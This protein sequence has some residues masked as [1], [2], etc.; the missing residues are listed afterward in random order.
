MGTML[1]SFDDNAKMKTKIK[2]IGVGGAGCNAVERMKSEKLTGVELIAMNT[3]AQQ[4]ADVSVDFLTIGPKIAKGQGAGSNP[5]VGEKA[6]LESK[7][8]ISN[9]IKGADMVYISAGMGGGTGSGA[10]PV[11]AEMARDL[12]ALTVAVVTK[13][14]KFEGP[15]R[16]RQAKEGLQKLKKC[17][18]TLIVINNQKIVD[19][20]KGITVPQAFESVDEV[21]YKSVKGITDLITK[22]GHVNLDF[23][24]VKTIMKRKEN[25]N[26]AS[27]MMG[28]GIFERSDVSETADSGM[29]LEEPY[30]CT[31][32]VRSAMNSTLLENR[33]LKG[34]KRILVNICGGT[35]LTMDDIAEGMQVIN[36]AAASNDINVIYGN[37]IDP[38]MRG[39]VSVTIIAT[40]FDEPESIQTPYVESELDNFEIDYKT[41]DNDWYEKEEVKEEQVAKEKV[42]VFA[43][44]EDESVDWEYPAFL[45]NNQD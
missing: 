5:E 23:S 43:N 20:F 15:V 12:G 19:S 32:A 17:V 29:M 2:V 16:M 45:R 11:I 38:E 4:L 22:K 39:K 37:V 18:D 40:G 14:F 28:V 44:G 26:G 31:E 27:A 8:E 35:D 1:F 41:S 24:D 9:F 30:M 36:E 25:Q 42:K 7:Q 13:P 21:L 34:A 3:D 6:A 10:A 33:E